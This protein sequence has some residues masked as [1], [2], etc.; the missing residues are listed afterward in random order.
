MQWRGAPKVAIRI[1][2]AGKIRVKSPSTAFGYL[3]APGLFESKT[4]QRELIILK[5]HVDNHEYGIRSCKGF[6]RWTADKRQEASVK[7]QIM[8]TD[9]R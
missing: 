7:R 2:D 4:D 3:N 5:S 9:G 6:Y 1:D 8:L